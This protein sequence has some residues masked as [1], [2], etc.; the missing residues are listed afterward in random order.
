MFSY[1]SLDAWKH[2]HATVLL[3]MRATDQ[4]VR[5]ESRDLFLQ[6]RRAVVSV[7]ANIVE[8]YALSTV[9]L[10]VKHLRIAFGSAAESECLLRSAKELEYLSKDVADEAVKELGTSMRLIYGLKRHPPKRFL[11]K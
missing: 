7:E 6:I 11:K 4:E 8:G 10:F 2:A 3:V 9:G 1:Q 5:S